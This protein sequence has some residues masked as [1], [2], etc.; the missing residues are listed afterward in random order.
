MEEEQVTQ[1]P[2]DAAKNETPEKPNQGING[3]L[4][5]I[6]A[7]VFVGI[8]GLMTVALILNYHGG[9][10]IEGNIISSLINAFKNMI[11]TMTAGGD[12][13]VALIASLVLS[14]IEMIIAVVVMVISV[15][16]TIKVIIHAAKKDYERAQKDFLAEVGIVALAFFAASW[17][18]GVRMGTFVIVMMALAVVAL[19]ARMI[20]NIVFNI[21][22]VTTYFSLGDIIRVAIGAALALVIIVCLMNISIGRSLVLAMG[23]MATSTVEFSAQGD[24][25][26]NI[27]EVAISAVCVIALAI[28]SVKL[29]KK[30]FG[31]LMNMGEPGF[32][33][34]L[35][36]PADKKGKVPSLITFVVWSAIFM[37]AV[38]VGK[39][40]PK[41]DIG[42]AVSIV[43]F[44]F[45]LGA[46]IADI[47]IGKMLPSK[48]ASTEA[49]A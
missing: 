30:R 8:V 1:T 11:D 27:I 45:A 23:G 9:A 16:L 43:S 14:V 24:K 36:T 40:Y 28:L 38:I 19:L 47:V 32:R 35:A 37:V 42:L 2:D 41:V 34:E 21:K 7:W 5:I 22:D 48:A 25:I 29:G 33:N 13:G 39:C 4:K 3:L 44:V 26:A 17:L 6:F 10:G 12:P 20:I 31:L 15:I 18:A 49:V 46:L